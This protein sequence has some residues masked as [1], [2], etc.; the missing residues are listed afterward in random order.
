MVNDAKPLVLGVVD[1]ICRTDKNKMSCADE[2][3]TK[4]EWV[5][6]LTETS[7]SDVVNSGTCTALRCSEVTFDFENTAIPI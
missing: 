4:W 2:F 5:E 7:F 6:F 1:L 3:K